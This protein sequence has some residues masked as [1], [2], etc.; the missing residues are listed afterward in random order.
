MIPLGISNEKETAFLRLFP[1]PS[2]EAVQ[3][4]YNTRE[5][6]PVIFELIDLSGKIVFSEELPQSAGSFILRGNFPAGIYTA[7]LKGN[8]SQLS[9][10]RLVRQ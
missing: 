4:E 3:V 10:F 2:T 1:N 5:A 9:T 7:V 6:G 8:G